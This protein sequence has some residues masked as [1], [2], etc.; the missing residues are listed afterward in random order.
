M[1]ESPSARLLA[2]FHEAGIPFD[3]VEDAWRRSEHLSPLLGWLTASFPD[4][5]A[6]QT[7]SEWLRLCASRV[8]GGEPAAALFAQ[9]RGNA[10]R[11]AHVAAGK[12]VDLRNECILARRPAA[13]AFADAANHLCEVWTAVTTHEE[14]G[15]TEPWGRAKAAA[16]AMVTAWLYQQE[17][18]EEDKQARLLA[19]AELTRLLREA[20]AAVR[21]DQP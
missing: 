11:Q 6:F 3:S 14:D 21:P 9:A 20:R 10:P 12:L 16:V 15:E 8:D 17:L 19:R 13:A 2:M 5:A 7:C 1:T 18:E 4:E